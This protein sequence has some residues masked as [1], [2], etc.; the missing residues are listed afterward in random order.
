MIQYISIISDLKDGG[1]NHIASTVKE[2]KKR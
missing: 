1:A 2:I